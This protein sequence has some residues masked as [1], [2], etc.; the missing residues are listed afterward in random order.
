MEGG[1][2]GNIAD[3]GIMRTPLPST[4]SLTH[5]LH[6]STPSDDDVVYDNMPGNPP[7]LLIAA[8]AG[9]EF[10]PHRQLQVQ[11]WPW[12]FVPWPAMTVATAPAAA[13]VP[14]PV[15]AAASPA[16]TVTGD[17]TAAAAGS[18]FWMGDLARLVPFLLMARFLKSAIVL[19]PVVAALMLKTM[20][21]PQWMP[22]CCL[23]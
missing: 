2:T 22:F 1:K 8:C 21:L 9:N 23:Q 15:A 13:P 7:K 12:P 4:L 10:I 16:R 5:S 3:Y 18:T 19:S 11:L 20:P 17:A 6:S 14:V